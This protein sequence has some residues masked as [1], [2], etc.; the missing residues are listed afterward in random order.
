MDHKTTNLNHIFIYMIPAFLGKILA[1]LLVPVYTMYLSPEEYGCFSLLLTVITLIAS[2]VSFGWDSALIRYLSDTSIKTNSGKWVSSIFSIRVF[3]YILLFV[4]VYYFHNEIAK[5]TGIPF[6]FSSLLLL[7]LAGN[8]M[9]DMVLLLKLIFRAQQKSKT[10]AVTEIG[11][12]LIVSFLSVMVLVVFSLGVPGILW[13]NF[14][15]CLIVFS[16]TIFHIRKHIKWT[17]PQ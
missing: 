1:I 3:G 2:L 15:G 13:A 14:L 4:L 8:L 17:I 16:A 7:A 6:H 10:F 12:T 9:T 5:M 11:K